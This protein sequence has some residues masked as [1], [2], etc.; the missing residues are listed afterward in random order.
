LPGRHPGLLRGGSRPGSSTRSQI[1]MVAPTGF[2]PV[3]Q[4]RSRFRQMSSVVADQQCPE[5]PTRLEHAVEK[6]LETSAASC[7]GP[8]QPATASRGDRHDPSCWSGSASRS[9]RGTGPPWFW[10]IMALAARPP[11]GTAA[12]RPPSLGTAA[13]RSPHTPRDCWPL[14]SSPQAGRS[15]GPPR[16]R[17]RSL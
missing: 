12:S 1:E 11:A 7:R 2:E 10:F 5:S 15:L 17:P 14:A 9:Q 6:F 13:C 3:F 16:S 4:S 8:V